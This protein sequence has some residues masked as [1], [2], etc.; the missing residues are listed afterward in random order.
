PEAEEGNRFLEILQDN[1]DMECYLVNTGSVGARAGNSGEKITIPATTGIMKALAKGGIRWE[2]DPDWG[3]QVAVGV[4][5]VDMDKYAPRQYYEPAEY[6]ALVEKLRQERR[7][8]LAQFPGLKPEILKVVE[9][10]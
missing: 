3:Y 6:E 1:P 8:W 5:G 2:K 7:Q 9:K 10:E 4:P